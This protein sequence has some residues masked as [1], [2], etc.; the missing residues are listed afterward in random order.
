MKSSLIFWI[1]WPI[2]ITIY[3]FMMLDLF[4]QCL[5]RR[6]VS[7]Y[8]LERKCYKCG[9]CCNYILLS[10][11]RFLD[12]QPSLGRWYIWWYTHI[13][14]FYLRNLDIEED[15]GFRYVVMG[16]RYLLS[17]HKCKHYLLRP[18]ICRQFPW[19]GYYRHPTIRKGCG[20]KVSL[21]KNNNCIK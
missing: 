10:W 16:C 4:I 19:N 18:A 15:N 11:P 13:H 12:V 17:D 8:K 20:Y 14:G 6:L 5:L 2:K 7:P 3:P 21:K 1:R 9:T